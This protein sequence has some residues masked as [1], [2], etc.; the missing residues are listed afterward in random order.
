MEIALGHR[1]RYIGN[2]KTKDAVPALAALAH[3]TRLAVFRLLV[4]AGPEGLTVG[5]VAEKLKVPN[6]T[7]SFHLKELVHTG[8]VLT[9]QEGRFIRCIANF[10]AMDQL[11]GYLTENCCGGESCDVR[12]PE[13]KPKP[14]KV[15]V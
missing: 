4:Q 13:C 12:A 8:L 1:F 9:E 2:M 15:T 10:A 11:I 14:K 6:P 5:T 3:D 7:M